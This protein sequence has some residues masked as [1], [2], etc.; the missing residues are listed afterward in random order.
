MGATENQDTARFNSIC[1]SFAGCTDGAFLCPSL[2]YKYYGLG[3]GLD[4]RACTGVYGHT[5]F[6]LSILY[7]GD[8]MHSSSHMAHI[9]Y[10]A[11]NHGDNAQTV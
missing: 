7:Y 11:D 10:C 6:A 8:T 3:I 9:L 2:Q 1:V 4:F 5:E